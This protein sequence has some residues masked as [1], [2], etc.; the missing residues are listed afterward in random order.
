VNG[1][2]RNKVVVLSGKGGTG[3]TTISAALT[4]LVKSKLTIDS[5]V[6][7]ANL[8][9]LLKPK[10]KNSFEFFSGKKAVINN[11]LCTNC[12]LCEQLC[13]FEAIQEFKIDKLSCEGCGLCY[14]VCPENA[15]SFNLNKSGSYFGCK[16]PD[17]SDYYFAQLF[18]GE[19]NSGK[20]VSE[21]IGKAIEENNARSEWLIIDGPPGIGCPVIASIYR[22]DYI[23]VVAESTI[24][25][26]HDLQRL[27]ALIEKSKI[28]TG[29]IINKYDLNGT[30][31]DE[32]IL[33]AESK[34]IS[35]LGLI[36]FNEEFVS[37]LIKCKNII[38]INKEIRE[39]I[40][41][42]WQKINLIIK[43]KQEVIN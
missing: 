43:G 32:I 8:H 13:R 22:A 37:A 41:N 1:L 20:L 14:R 28:K 31:T 40:I 15:I 2:I 39:I 21:L 23:I 29:I 9:L 10:I 30:I 34:N 24:S 42:I 33:Y 4:S 3:K 35:I 36:P 17:D 18:P 19:G 16:L 38:D 5:D 7:A 6:D 25:G 12:G 26:F 11:D 27:V